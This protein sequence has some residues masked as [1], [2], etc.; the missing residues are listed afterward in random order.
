MTTAEARS[1]VQLE[2]QRRGRTWG[3]SRVLTEAQLTEARAEMMF[4]RGWGWNA[5]ITTRILTRNLI[6][7]G[8]GGF[9]AGRGGGS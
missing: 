9:R 8:N 3:A 4:A 6:P 1:L 7:L 2:C 5:S